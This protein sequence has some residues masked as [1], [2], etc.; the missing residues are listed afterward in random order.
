MQKNKVQ[1][2]LGLPER[3][4]KPL[5]NGFKKKKYFPLSRN[6]CSFLA[7]NLVQQ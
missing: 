6:L 7:K 2:C 1:F 3:R 4:L 5:E